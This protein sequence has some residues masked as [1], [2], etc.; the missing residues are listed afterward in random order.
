MQNKFNGLWTVEFIVGDDGLGLGGPNRLGYGAAVIN[1]IRVEGGNSEYY[2]SGRYRP[3]AGAMQLDLNMT[4]HSGAPALDETW[5]TIARRV[6]LRGE[7]PE[8]DSPTEFEVKGV[9]G[10]TTE[11]GFPLTMRFVKRDL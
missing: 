7:A 10:K 4:M 3:L 11:V 2:W 5:A 9:A 1:R 6:C 8:G